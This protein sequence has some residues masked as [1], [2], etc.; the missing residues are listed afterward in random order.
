[1][2]VYSL[3]S[4]AHSCV[5]C[6]C[7]IANVLRSHAFAGTGGYAEKERNDGIPKGHKAVDGKDFSVSAHCRLCPDVFAMQ[8]TYVGMRHGASAV[9]T[10]GGMHADHGTFRLLR[11][12][13]MRHTSPSVSLQM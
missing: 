3:V 1:V 6:K 7:C 9:Y 4:E 10:E 11:M 12:P 13:R 2:D 8:Q 5:E